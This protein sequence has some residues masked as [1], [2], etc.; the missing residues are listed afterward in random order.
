M[1]G[2]AVILDTGPLVA[3]LCRSDRWHTAGGILPVA[4]CRWHTAGGI[5]P[6]AY[7]WPTHPL[8]RGFLRVRDAPEF[9]LTSDQSTTPAFTGNCRRPAD[10]AGG[11]SSACPPGGQAGER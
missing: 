6:V 1:K 2:F 3:W 5:L 4:Y 7:C 11:S 10:G 9:S 8:D